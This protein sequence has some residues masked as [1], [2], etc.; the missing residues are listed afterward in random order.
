MRKRV[1][2]QLQLETELREA[3]EQERLRVF[4][5]PIVELETGGLSGL[6]ALARWPSRGR[7]EISPT[8]FIPVAE[9]TGL[10]RPLGRLVLREACSQMATGAPG[11]VERRRDDQG[12]VSAGQFGAPDLLADVARRSAESGLPAQAL[13]LEI[14][15]DTIMRDPNG[16]PPCST[17]SR[18]RRRGADRRLRNRLLVAQLPASLRRRHAQDRPLVHRLDVRATKAAPRSCARSSRWRQP[19]PRGDRRGG[20]DGGPAT[21]SAGLA[22]VTRR[23]FCFPGRSPDGIESL[24]RT[25]APA[26]VAVP[27]EN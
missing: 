17:S 8:E 20:R 14:T 9:D 26:R 10:I 2:G 21:R 3:I 1:V 24:L 23:A 11:L 13:R 18:A 7:R 25:W 6:E 15:E 19:R 22:G 27:A 4:Y 12:N 5:Q 16:C